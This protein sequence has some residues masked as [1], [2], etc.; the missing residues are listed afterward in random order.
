MIS[1]ALYLASFAA[2]TLVV[3]TAPAGLLRGYVLAYNAASVV[4]SMSLFA[5]FSRFATAR[6]SIVLVGGFTMSA[7]ILSLGVGWYKAC[8]FAYPGLLIL[9]DYLVT[10]SHGIRVVTCFRLLMIVSA[11]PFLI[12]P[13]LFT[14]NLAS[15]VALL[16]VVSIALV[17]TAKESHLLAV[18]SPVRY[19]VGNYLFYNG[20]LSLL[21]LII[22]SPD[23]L[24]WWYLATQISLVLVLKVLDYSLR[25]AYSLE[26]RTRYTALIVA[27]SL[28]LIAFVIRP[29]FGPLCLAYLGFFGLVWT[30]RYISQ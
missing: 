6:R 19:Q 29:A 5:Y 18:S 16:Q 11:A 14:V 24:R 9:T 23:I 30:G 21:A 3:L 7:L 8:L 20:T 2:N 12:V 25:R 28:P 22:R 15:R 1:F 26:P 10:Q 27:G 4:F 13:E 17:A